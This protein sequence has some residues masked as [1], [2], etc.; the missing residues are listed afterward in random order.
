MPLLPHGCQCSEI[1]VFPRNW[2]TV[3]ASIKLNWRIQVEAKDQTIRFQQV[4]IGKCQKEQ[5][6]SLKKAR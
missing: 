3:S 6:T 1:S 5:K 4:L 2:G